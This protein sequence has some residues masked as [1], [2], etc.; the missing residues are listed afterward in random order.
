[1]KLNQAITA[2]VVLIATFNLWLLPAVAENGRGQVNNQAMNR[3]ALLFAVEPESKVNVYAKPSN[4]DRRIGYGLSGD[5]V[6]LLRQVGS[7]EGSTWDYV[8][9]DNPPNVEGWVQEKF[10]AV[11]EA[12]SGQSSAKSNLSGGYLG[13]QSPSNHQSK[14]QSQYRKNPRQQQN[15]YSQ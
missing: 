1:M 10:V 6:T 11:Q 4:R 15:R 7:N 3:P 12:Q 5:R 2:L 13:N 9:F 14:Y 8:R